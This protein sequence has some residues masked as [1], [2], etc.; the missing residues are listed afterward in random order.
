MRIFY[1]SGKRPNGA[2]M[3]S[4][5]WYENLFMA[6]VDLGHDVVEFDYDLEP[7]LSAAD[8]LV[9][10]NAEFV[11]RHRPDAEREL[12]R[13]L[14]SSHAEKPIDV[15]FSY[16]YSS[17]T[18]AETIAAIRSMGIRTMNWYCNG[19][20]QLHLVADIAPAYDWCL[21]PEK[22]RIEDYRALGANPV[23]FQ[24]AANPRI[25][26]PRDV[27]RAFDVTFVGARYADRPDHIK[28]LVDAGIDARAFGPGWLDPVG[29][30]QIESL[31]DVPRFMVNPRAWKRV[32]ARAYRRVFAPERVQPILP[33]N[34]C[35]PMLS[36]EDMIAMYSR[37]N[38][39]LGFSTV[40]SDPKGERIVQIRL[41]DFEAPMSGAFY[42]LE[43]QPEFEEFFEIGTEIACYR[44][45]D[46]L[47]TQ[48]E[49]YLAHPAERETIRRA[50]HERAM[51]DHTWQKRF[52]TLFAQLELE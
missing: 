27:P 32:A 23:Y 15:F 40:D 42:M 45:M 16:F 36:D 9:P 39:S 24:E 29:I 22:Y 35:G 10:S 48:C 38:I 14:R 37:S 26:A 3:D 1:A 11:E 49:Y 2:L 43:Y 34:A 18:T 51:R 52:K 5:I 20:Y 46:D 25:Y 30:K 44:G 47:V 50:G 8:L 7:L 17:C 13:Q 41:R 6:L 33:R 12:L 31:A 28:A 4:Q 19:S 21:V